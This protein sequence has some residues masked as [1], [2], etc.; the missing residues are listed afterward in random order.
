MAEAPAMV[1]LVDLK[2]EVALRKM[3]QRRSTRLERALSEIMEEPY[4]RGV[5]MR[6]IAKAA[7]EGSRD[8]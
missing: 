2:A 7:L 4:Y 6:R 1:P 8:A 3:Y 5:S